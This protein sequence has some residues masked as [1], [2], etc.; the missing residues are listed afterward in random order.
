LIKQ[1]F[2]E[3]FQNF[4]MINLYIAPILMDPQ[5]LWERQVNGAIC[6]PPFLKRS[7]SMFLLRY[8]CIH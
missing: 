4:D 5:G 8:F 2:I 3:L 7:R 1:K 6:S